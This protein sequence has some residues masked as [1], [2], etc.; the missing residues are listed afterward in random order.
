[1]TTVQGTA[2]RIATAD[3]EADAYVARP[4]DGAAH[5][6]VLL[7]PD[8]LGIRPA[9][10]DMADRLAAAGY[11]VLV[12]NVFYRHG[13]APTI[14]DMPDV[15]P[16]DQVWEV[17]GKALQVAN[18]LASD[19]AMRD[20]GSWLDW[21]EADP[22]TSDGKLG[23]TGYCHG[24]MMSLRTAGTYPDR[25][26]AVAIVHG[27]HLITD[28]DDSPHLGVARITGEVFFANG[29][30]DVVT[31]PPEAARFEQIMRDGDVRFRSEM[32][33]GANHGFTAPDFPSMYDHDA[34]EAHWVGL[35][36]LFGRTLGARGA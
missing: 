26:A 28:D 33:P 25:L 9:V 7:Y 36:D 20:A 29:D 19:D 8:L 17:A 34:T 27:S 1:M 11:T 21:L 14:P 2:L 3:G 23:V 31:P 13:P 15:V 30:Q 4:D 6:G 5:P 35:L 18:Q 32:Y 22:L 12:P 16:A 24:G 10:T